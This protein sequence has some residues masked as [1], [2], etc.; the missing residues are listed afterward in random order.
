MNA[1]NE[2]IRRLKK[3]DYTKIS[4]ELYN[5]S[6]DELNDKEYIDILKIADI[7]GAK[8]KKFYKL[9]NNVDIKTL[10]SN[11]IKT[12]YTPTFNRHSDLQ[13]IGISKTKT[14]FTIYNEFS[15]TEEVL[16]DVTINN[17]LYKK[18]KNID[19]RRVMILEKSSDKPYLIIS[20]DP[21]GE[22]SKVAKRLDEYLIK[23][24]ENLNLDFNNFFDT[25]EIEK[26]IHQLVEKEIVVPNKLVAKDEA[27]KRIKSVSA[28]VKDN[29]SDDDIYGG[30][31]KCDLKLENIR[32]KFNKETIE[33]FGKT[34]LKI[35]TKANKE[36]TDA[37]TQ[38]IISVL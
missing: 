35:S 6:F 11:L 15:T 23:L 10:T 28:M 25:I 9:K 33:L 16:V 14:G 20:I 37:L 36:R 5:K 17:Q 1:K 29:I 13:T 8:Y 31:K 3:S 27:T 34:L 4:K 22:G 30:C 19:Y 18:I 2:I 21:V 32:M 24:I 12:D 26:A 7:Y 38:N